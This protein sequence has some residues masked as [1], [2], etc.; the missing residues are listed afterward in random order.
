MRRHFHWLFWAGF[1]AMLGAD[2]PADANRVLSAKGLRR[3]ETS[4][5]LPA[6][7]DIQ[8]RLNRL[9]RLVKENQAALQRRVLRSVIT[10]RSQ[11][12]L[13]DLQA[14]Q[15]ALNAMNAS[16]L[17]PP[18]LV[19]GPVGLQ[20]PI[21]QPG[22]GLEEVS[23]LNR[24]EITGMFNV[25][26]GVDADNAYEAAE[27]LAREDDFDRGLARI[28]G[29]IERLGGAYQTIKA[30]PEVPAALGTLTRAEN[31]PIRLGPVSEY[32]KTLKHLEEG[33]AST[34]M[35]TTAKGGTAPD[36]GVAAN[37]VQ[38]ARLN[39]RRAL[40]RL[41]DWE[42]LEASQPS[43]V[44]PGA[45]ESLR[46]EVAGRRDR[47]ARS[48]ALLRRAYDAYKPPPAIEVKTVVRL[49]EFPE[50]GRIRAMVER[51]QAERRASFVAEAE[52]ALQTAK[53]PLQGQAGASWAR[54]TV[55]GVPDLPMRVD[56]RAAEVRVSERF[57]RSVGLEPDPNTHLGILKSVKLGPFTVREVACRVVPGKE[58][59]APPVLGIPVFGQFVVE[60]DEG[61]DP[62]G[63]TLTRVEV[64]PIP[65]R[66]RP[67]GAPPAKARR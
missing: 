14:W 29:A 15:L 31:Q 9:E 1:P 24:Q 28:R 38:G 21:G 8:A 54:V 65:P 27:A 56:L 59:S 53:V 4:F 5:V 32:S 62:S 18:P 7:G 17:F 49:P 57:A 43:T 39:L 55:N 20:Y 13:A 25:V 67:P 44:E 22:A 35:L 63:L 23:N 3:V 61:P 33:M 16:T 6:E 26:A 50:K 60:V 48:V 64:A 45:G 10:A 40:G 52:G 2:A 11:S 37:L 36:Y 30:D 42:R 47:F 46:R 41:Q 58:A 66:P 51:Q 12:L 19:N 34:R